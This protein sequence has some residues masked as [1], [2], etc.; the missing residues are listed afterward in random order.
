M[1]V[2]SLE[3]G[4]EGAVNPLECGS[5]FSL[6]SGDSFRLRIFLIETGFGPRL[7]PA[8]HEK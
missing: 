1:G 5:S 2:P 3:I 6:G 4:A 7:A 8:W